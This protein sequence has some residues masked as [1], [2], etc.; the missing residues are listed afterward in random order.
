MTPNL[1]TVVASFVLPSN[2]GFAARFARPNVS[3]LDRHIHVAIV[4]NV[5]RYQQKCIFDNSL[6]GSYNSR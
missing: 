3:Y 2:T 6:S 1:L 5:L 4:Q